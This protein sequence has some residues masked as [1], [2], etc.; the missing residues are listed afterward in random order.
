[1]NIGIDGGPL[2]ITDDRLKVGV[3]RDTLE[4]IA[5]LSK[6]GENHTFTVYCFTP[7]VAE[8]GERF[9]KNVRVKMLMPPAGFMRVRLPFELWRNPV[10]VFIGTAQAIPVTRVPTI[11]IVNDLGFLQYPQTYGDSAKE[12]SQQTSYLVKHASHIIA[13]SNTTKQ[14]IRRYYHID[15]KR[16]TVCYPGV[17]SVFSSNGPRNSHPRSYVLFVGSLTKTK[18][19]PRAIRIFAQFR[20]TLGE[21][22]DFFLA[23][24]DFWPDPKI[25]QTID[26]L[27]MNES[28][29]LLGRIIDEKLADLYRGATAFFTAS[30]TE[31]F[32]LPAIEAMKSGTPVV[33]LDHGALAEI[34]AD[35]G[36]VV[37]DENKAVDALVAMTDKQIRDTYAEKALARAKLFSWEKSAKNILE[38]SEHL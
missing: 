18:N 1:M 30:L 15:P 25:K 8:V 28:V 27:Q 34:V 24:G 11:G 7:P 16:V 4:L 35:G 33:A 3:Y 22:F 2:S 38:I 13:I 10:D 6:I 21:P 17:S 29:H 9:G 23:G 31:G 12:L 26:E 20:L 14:D 32:C 37:S 19:I 36:I 5:T